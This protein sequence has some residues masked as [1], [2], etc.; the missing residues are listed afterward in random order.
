M[1]GKWSQFGFLC[2]LAMLQGEPQQWPYPRF[3]VQ[4]ILCVFFRNPNIGK[5]LFFNPSYD[6]QNPCE[7][8]ITKT[9]GPLM[10]TDYVKIC[11][12]M[13]YYAALIV[14]RSPLF[15]SPV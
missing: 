8:Y 2:M 7:S 1:E 11:C 6:Q 3:S 13:G 9:F 4:L 10:G 12:R 15:A 14:M 5:T